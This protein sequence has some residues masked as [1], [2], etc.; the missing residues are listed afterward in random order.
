MTS[1]LMVSGSWPPQVCGVGDYTEKLCCELESRA[2]SV[3]RFA[4]SRLPQPLSLQIVNKVGKID[5]DVVHIQYP[6]AGYGR[7]LTPSVLASSIRN[8]P[9]IVTLHEYSSFRW[10]RRAWFW[11]F[12]RHCA[13]RIFT[14]DHE[15]SLFG[16]RFFTRN[17]RDLTVEIA[18]NIPVS[19]AVA[20]QSGRVA[21]FGLIA[22]NKGIEAFLDLC[23]IARA[24]GSDLTFEIIGAIP[25]RYRRYADAI[26]QRAAMCGALTALDLSDDVVARRLAGSTFAYLPFPDGASAKRGSLA[27]AIV[28]GVIVVT[29]HSQITPD[30]VRSA[31]AEANTP[32]DAFRVITRMNNE[33]QPRSEIAKNVAMAAMRFNWSAIASRHTD[34]YRQV[35]SGEAGGDVVSADIVPPADYESRLAS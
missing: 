14:T 31:T 10:Y 6:T 20:R 27:A 13:A 9:V 28:N 29:R 33:R 21:Y 12:A 26:W 2:I 34:L 11:P 35:L 32:F 30:W 17:G 19:P 3:I 15:R 18:S 4:S 16:R 22:P 24:A 5:C 8:R 23:E 7:S 25:A 1:V